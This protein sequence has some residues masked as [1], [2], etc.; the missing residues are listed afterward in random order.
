MTKHPCGALPVRSFLLSVWYC[1]HHQAFFAHAGHY[2][3]DGTGP[4]DFTEQALVEFGP[5]DD[6]PTVHA[7]IRAQWESWEPVRDAQAPPGAPRRRSDDAALG[8]RATP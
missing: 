4:L 7:W 8:S 3:E 6:L 5:F 2:V 1:D